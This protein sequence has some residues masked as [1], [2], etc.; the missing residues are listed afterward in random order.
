MTGLEQVGQCRV[1]GAGEDPAVVQESSRVVDRLQSA[2]WL[3]AALERAPLL[4]LGE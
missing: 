2:L 3:E 1:G 4:K